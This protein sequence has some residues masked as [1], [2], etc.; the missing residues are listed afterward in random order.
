[1]RRPGVPS[2]AGSLG[3][4]ANLEKHLTLCGSCRHYLDQ[5]RL[6]RLAAGKLRA[7]DVPADALDAF[8]HAFREWKKS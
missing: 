4:Q 7:E 1:V 3:S 5:M 6:T 2:G 8:R